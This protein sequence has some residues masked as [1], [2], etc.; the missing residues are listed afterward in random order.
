MIIVLMVI[1]FLIAALLVGI[2]LLQ[3]NEQGALGGLS[4]GTGGLIST[5]GTA[6]LLTRGTAI[7][8]AC[9]FAT[10]LTLALLFKNAGRETKSFIDQGPVIEETIATE[11]GEDED[12]DGSISQEEAPGEDSSIPQSTVDESTASESPSASPNG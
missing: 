1:H 6:N 8:G 7:L 2:I 5:R 3:K 10:S 9:F 4:S 11:E 12:L